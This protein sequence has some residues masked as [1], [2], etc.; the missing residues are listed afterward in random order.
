MTQIEI[1]PC[2]SDNYAY[3]VKSGDQ[4]AIV[5]PSEAAPV[6]AALVAA[7]ALAAVVRRNFALATAYNLVAISLVF[8][9][10]M[11]PVL[12]AIFMP[13]SSISTVMLTA[14]SLSER[15]SLWKS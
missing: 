6:R 5:D 11:S 1:V 4:C 13:V 10:V 14:F 8:A 15:S 12:A 7:G 2:L 3:L 9:G